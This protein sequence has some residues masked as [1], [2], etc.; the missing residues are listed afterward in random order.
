[1]TPVDVMLVHSAEQLDA[2]E[3]IA[4]GLAELVCIAE[5]ACAPCATWW[6]DLAELAVLAALVFV[7][8]RVVDG[9]WRDHTSRQICRKRRQTPSQR[10]L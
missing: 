8:V 7:L 1:M 9:R 2:I 4:N 5:L 6:C 3:A 10:G